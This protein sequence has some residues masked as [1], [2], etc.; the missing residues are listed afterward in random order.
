MNLV[1]SWVSITHQVS[2]IFMQNDSLMLASAIIFWILMSDSDTQILIIQV[3]HNTAIAE[4]FRDGCS[5]PKK[6]IEVLNGVKVCYFFLLSCG[7]LKI[8]NFP[9]QILFVGCHFHVA[10]LFNLCILKYWI[11]FALMPLPNLKCYED[12]MM[13]IVI[14]LGCNI[15]ASKLKISVVFSL[16]TLWQIAMDS[17]CLETR[18]IS[19][20]FHNFEPGI[21]FFLLLN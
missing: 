5:D 10:S 13:M 17:L 18:L 8:I 4:Y 21:F 9:P 3:L 15:G 20:G 1:G 2:I 7:L 14:A 11:Q 6:F 19:G 16:C 12:L